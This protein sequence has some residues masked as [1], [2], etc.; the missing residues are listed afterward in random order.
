MKLFKFFDYV[1][2]FK[3]F[4]YVIKFE[5]TKDVSYGRWS[6]SRGEMI[7]LDEMHPYHLLNALREEIRFETNK[8]IFG[9]QHGIWNEY[10]TRMAEYTKKAEV[11]K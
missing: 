9:M 7:H 10:F 3:F 2:K 4:G 1:L 6:N 5:I 8:E 11:T